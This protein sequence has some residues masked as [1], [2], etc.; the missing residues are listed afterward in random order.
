MNQNE[1]KLGTAPVGKLLFEL[2]LP[3]IAAQIVNLLSNV[4]DRIYIGH[5]PEVGATALTGLGIA[6]PIIILIAAFSALFGFGGAP[7][8][9]IEMGRG[10]HG[11]AEEIL[12]NSLCALLVSGGI[13]SVIFFIFGD[14]FLYLFGASEDTIGYASGYLHIYV[15]GSVFVLITTGMNAFITSQ[16]FARMAMFTT[17]IGAGLNIVLD[18]VFIFG[19][20]MGVKG[21]ALATILSQAVSAAWVL[22]FLFSDKTV[23]KIR[24]GNLRIRFRVIAPVMALGVSPFIMQSTESLISVCFNTSLQK[25]GGDVAVGSMT[26]MASLMQ[27]VMMPLQGLTQGMQPIISYNYGAGNFERVKQLYRWM[28][29]LC[30][31]FMLVTTATTMLFPGFYAGFFT[32]E[33]QLIELVRR[34]MPVFM[35]GMMV[36]G[37]Q[38]GIQPTFLALGQ[39]KISLF[40]AVLRKIILLIPLAIILPHFMG[41]MGVYYAEPVSDI[42]S[43]TT[44]SVLFMLNIRKILSMEALQKIK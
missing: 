25:Y 17:L 8:A 19:F 29:G 9:A 23:L 27:A 1:E 32:N 11:R 12:G 18:P 15:L 14:T 36:F 24:P 31:G 30:F 34:V 16:G 10:N 6:F 22:K 5:I 2:A 39:A 44:A 40:I 35:A 33:T 41:V 21:A 42:L 28:I 13:L 7:R 43:A 37:L 20:R 26:I 38:N 3:A 4:V